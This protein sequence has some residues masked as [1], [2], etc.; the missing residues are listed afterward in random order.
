MAGAAALYTHYLAVFL[1]GALFVLCLVTGRR[2]SA[3]ALG[4]SVALFLPWVPTLLRQPAAATLWMRESGARSAVGFLSSLGG[5]GRI[6]DPLGGPLPAWLVLAGSAIGAL[7][8]VRFSSLRRTATPTPSVARI[9]TIATVC[10]ILLAGTIRPVDFAGRSEMVVL[11]VWMWAVAQ[12]GDSSRVARAGAWA[13]VALGIIGNILSP[14]GTAA[15]AHGFR[16]GGVGGA[17][18]PPGDLVV[19]GFPFY[20][21]PGW[22]RTGETV[23]RRPRSGAPGAAAHPGWSSPPAPPTEKRDALGSCGTARR[24]RGGRVL[25]L[26]QPAE[27]TPSFR[28]QLSA[29]GRVGRSCA[30]RKRRDPLG[31]EGRGR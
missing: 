5:V 31:G 12:A 19:A 30:T 4:V 24:L 8:L 16:G 18:R 27:A 10:A 11:G 13:A 14:R 15:A 6:P 9:L 17:V 29:R 7:L 2:R 26:L 1:V 28:A 3:A 22:K 21:P 20:L 23:P 25:F